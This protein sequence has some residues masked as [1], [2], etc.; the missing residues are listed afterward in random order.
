MPNEVHRLDASRR[1]D[2]FR[3][4]SEANGCGWCC[5]VAW[6]VPTW[7]GWGERTAE[8][9]LRLREALFDRGE[10]DGYLLYADGAPAGWCQAGPRDRL[11]KLVRQYGLSPDPEAWALTCFLMA[12]PFRRRGLAT[13][14]L[15]EVVRDL[16]RRGVPRVQAFP[17]RGQNLE[18][19]DLW[20]GPESV[21]LSAG[22]AVLRS[23]SRRPV[24]EL[25]LRNG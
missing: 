15:S 24:L 1:A 19:D 13:D 5:C 4:H 20:T 9:N 8:E 3:L 11:E 6:W 10:Y 17:K 7:E 2:F 23:D 18:P 12:P 22:F 21:F 25:D 16:R 14:L